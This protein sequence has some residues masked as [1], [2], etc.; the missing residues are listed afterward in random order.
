MASLYIQLSLLVW[1]ILEY[2]CYAGH[3]QS[4]LEPFMVLLSLKF[5][6]VANKYSHELRLLEFGDQM[7]YGNFPNNYEIFHLYNFTPTHDEPNLV[8]KNYFEF[9]GFQYTSVDRNG[10]HGA[11]YHD[12]RQ[13]MAESDTFKNLKYNIITN[14]GFSEHVGEGDSEQNLVYNQYMIFRNFH[15]LGVIG[16]LYFHVLP[17]EGCWN[18]HGVCDYN[19]EF[20]IQLAGKSKYNHLLFPTVLR[21]PPYDIANMV[22]SCFIKTSD[23]PFMSLEDF[24]ALSALPRSIYYTYNTTRVKLTYFDDVDSSKV[25]EL[26]HDVNISDSNHRQLVRNF[27]RDVVQGDDSDQCYRIICEAGHCTEEP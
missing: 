2:K 26:S 16:T 5:P 20:F 13:D 15:N 23:E 8:M 12:V 25:T 9:I 27:C 19:T 18:R 7:F 1:I 6:K 24:K 10:L 17:K 21:N 3:V 4:S 22:V 14:F 11:I